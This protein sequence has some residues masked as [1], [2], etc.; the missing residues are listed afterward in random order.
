MDQRKG[1][2]C[3]YNCRP[4]D[5]VQCGNCIFP[6]EALY[7]RC[8]C[9]DRTSQLHNLA[10]W[11]QGREA[12][13]NLAQCRYCD[14]SE[15]TELKPDRCSV[16][17]SRLPRVMVEASRD[18]GSRIPGFRN[19]RQ[20]ALTSMQLV[21]LIATS[22]GC[23]AFRLHWQDARMHDVKRRCRGVGERAR[24]L[25]MVSSPSPEIRG[26]LQGLGQGGR[27]KDG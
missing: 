1:A 5:F 23:F 15:S 25:A 12:S 3:N 13:A 17:R 18:A 26:S 8:D 7:S 14:S 20:A 10:W 9:R 16:R 22:R 21:L 11:T 19:R 27:S 4:V 24:G 2:N 6:D